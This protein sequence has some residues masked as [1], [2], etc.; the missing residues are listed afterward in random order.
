MCSILMCSIHWC[1]SAVFYNVKDAT[2]IPRINIIAHLHNQIEEEK[3]WQ[4][5]QTKRLQKSSCMHGL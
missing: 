3:E 4:Q 5:R 1:S 2:N